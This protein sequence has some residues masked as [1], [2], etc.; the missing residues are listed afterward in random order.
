[1][2]RVIIGIGG[3]TNG[4]KT[5][6]SKHLQDVLPKSCVIS[7]DNFFKDESMVAVDINGFKQFDALDALHMDRMMSDVDSWQNDPES[8][9]TSRGLT[10]TSATS[11]QPNVLIVEGFLIF[12]HGSRVYVPPD[13][14]DYFDGHVW[15]M[16]LKNRKEMEEAVNDIVF[17][18]GTQKQE[19]LLSSV[20]AD[21]QEIL[22]VTQS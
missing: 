2:K 12:N 14:P 22:M 21:I 3:M 16:Y 4:G 10:V 7:Q 15:P 8:F 5:T 20:L 1:M 19:V 6:L 13:P 11:Q 9:M 18:D 17:L